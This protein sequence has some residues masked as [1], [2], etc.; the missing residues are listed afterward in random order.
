MTEPRKRGIREHKSSLKLFEEASLADLPA[1]FG[2]MGGSGSHSMQR[3]KRSVSFSEEKNTY[4]SDD[5]KETKTETLEIVFFAWKI[6][7]LNR[8]RNCFIFLALRLA[9]A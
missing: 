5:N 2:T 6:L 3:R 8:W 7:N 4:Y 1:A 9:M